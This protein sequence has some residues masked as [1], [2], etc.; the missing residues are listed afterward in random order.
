MDTQSQKGLDQETIDSHVKQEDQDLT[1][2][3]D[4]DLKQEEVHIEISD[5]EGEVHGDNLHYG[6]ESK[7]GA[8]GDQS[9]SDDKTGKDSKNQDT[10]EKPAES[11]RP[12]S[13]RTG[14][15]TSD[16]QD[17]EGAAGAGKEDS[18]K[19]RE[20]ARPVADRIDPDRFDKASCDRD[21]EADDE[22]GDD[23]ISFEARRSSVKP[24]LEAVYEE[25]EA[26]ADEEVKEVLETVKDDKA[27]RTSVN[28]N[29]SLVNLMNKWNVEGTLN[30]GQ[31]GNL[32]NGQIGAV[33]NGQVGNLNNGQV[34]NLNNGQT[35]G[36]N[37]G[38]IVDGFKPV[39][40]KERYVKNGGIKSKFENGDVVLEVPQQTTLP[41]GGG[42]SGGNSPTPQHEIHDVSSFIL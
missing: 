39:K 21:E 22:A 19:L 16:Q 3:G 33:N 29:G 37:N 30:N 28:T 42:R 25:A 24:D 34:G 18:D 7:E 9:E 17:A 31:V 20:K 6:V 2:E 1:L 14:P 10:T 5:G 35:G 13:E 4:E 32:N 23:I 36:L 38:Q 15:D 26:D 27:K 40:D 8:T 41:E 11:R 12:V